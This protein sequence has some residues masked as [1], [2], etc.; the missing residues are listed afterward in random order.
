M[1]RLL[2]KSSKRRGFT[3][4]ELS[5]V[6][7]IVS[8]LIT[9]AISVSVN[10]V[11]KIKIDDTKQ[12]ME[13]IYKALK[14]YVQA[15]NALPCPA[16][17][18]AVKTATNKYGLVA[19]TAGTCSDDPDGGVYNGTDTNLAYGMVPVQS[20]GL[21]EK[22]AEDA[23]GTKFSYV[24]EK[25]L[26]S[27][28]SYSNTTMIH[29]VD[30]Y[31]NT[32]STRAISTQAAFA[33]ISHGPNKLGA[34]NANS[35][36]SISR[37]SA[38]N[39]KD[40]DL[41]E[42]SDYDAVFVAS[43]TWDENY[44]DIV[45][46]KDIRNLLVDANALKAITCPAGSATNGGQQDPIS[47][48]SQVMDW[49]VAEYGQIATSTTNCPTN[50]TAGPVRPTKKCGAFGNWEHG[51]VS[52]CLENGDGTY[53]GEEVAGDLACTGG[54]IDSSSV[55]DY[56][57]HIFTS[58]ANLIC[59]GTGDLE[60]LI[61][62]GGGG[63][64][65]L[66][67]NEGGGGGGGGGGVSSGVYSVE[68]GQT[69]S[70]IVGA[71]GAGGTT[72]NG[73][74]GVASFF[75]I[76]SALGGDGGL[77]G[78]DRNGVGGVSGGGNLGGSPNDHDNDHVAGGGG[79]GM[80][81]AGG[82]ST[83]HDGGVGGNGVTSSIT[84]T[85]VTYG[86]GGGGGAGGGRTIGSFGAGGTESG[87]NGAADNIAAVAGATNKGGG[88]GGGAK[89]N[90]NGAGG[91]SGVVI[92]RYLTGGSG[93]NPCSGGSITYSGGKTIHTFTTS[94]SLVCSQAVN[95]VSYLVVAGGGGGGGVSPVSGKYGGG[96]GGGGGGVCTGTY[97]ISA[98]T[99]TVTVGGGGA[100][101]VT[102]NGSSGASSSISGSL[103]VTST[104]GSGG[105]YGPDQDTTNPNG[106]GD[107]GDGGASGTGNTG[108]R[109]G[110]PAYDKGHRHCAGGGGS[111]MANSAV[112]NQDDGDHDGGDGAAGT[113]NSISGNLYYYGSGG[114]GGAGEDNSQG[115]I[116]VGGI[117]SGGSGG[118]QTGL[119][120]SGVKGGGGGGG[121]KAGSGGN[122]GSGIVIFS[123]TTPVS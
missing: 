77:Y 103:S 24:V 5:V 62:A 94:G 60:Y 117:N 32:G 18:T 88:G 14:T 75:G 47:Y 25:G 109:L 45:F 41:D 10:K 50:Y 16:S 87:G 46:F 93:S 39:E 15:N 33:I 28:L 71:G 42:S 38:T 92:V 105:I 82:N 89:D 108:S 95:N 90:N 30:S 122:G 61:V 120:T 106:A 52:P 36:T 84:G 29:I 74:A 98:E 64:G 70:I 1:R 40:N 53:G 22:F 65:G 114:G 80:A 59:T 111:S 99:L 55:P 34:Y 107:G 26:T 56:T 19:G 81:N 7:V 104:G 9:G 66:L 54:T 86:S 49:P 3:L 31:D 123:Y 72:G 51:T 119:A 11:K 4:I 121:S 79:G 48:G 85:S 100:G 78:G 118:S 37:S 76:N 63:G 115:N 6:I 23:F 27:A 20:L 8:I 97:N 57:V 2:R 68:D 112:I 101:G 116:G 17:I 96:G 43:A 102:S 110:G 91:G 67:D 69:I 113:A 73:G 13:V 58:S 44:D 35:S 12:R 21:S 83:N